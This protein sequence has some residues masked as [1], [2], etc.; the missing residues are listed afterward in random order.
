MGHTC[1]SLAQLVERLTVVVQR[2]QHVAG[3]IPA[4]RIPFANTHFMAIILNLWTLINIYHLSRNVLLHA[5]LENLFEEG[6]KL[7]NYL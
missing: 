5:N 6:N 4:A 1:P 3:S 2:H 7:F